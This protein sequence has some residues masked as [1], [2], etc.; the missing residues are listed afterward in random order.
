MDVLGGD[1]RGG[2]GLDLFCGTGALGLEALSRGAREV[3]F[4]EK[5]RRLCENLKKTL[6]RLGLKRS[7]KVY[8]QD[9]LRQLRRFSEGRILFDFILADPPYERGWGSRLVEEISRL[10]VLSPSG[11]LVIEMSK[12]EVVPDRLEPL[13]KRSEK[14]YGDTVVRYFQ[15]EP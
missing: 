1:L 15:A 4:V 2:L 7:A 9:A 3:W 10:R 8:V 13:V 5:E 14:R 12:R 6:H 11:W